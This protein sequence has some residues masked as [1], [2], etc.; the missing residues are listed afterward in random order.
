MDAATLAAYV[1]KNWRKITGMPAKAKHEEGHWP[2]EVYDLIEEHVVDL[3][4]F[5]D[6]WTMLRG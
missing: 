2:Q 5:Q 1:D 4:E 3:D 6:E